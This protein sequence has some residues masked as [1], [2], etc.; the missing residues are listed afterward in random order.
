[1]NLSPRRVVGTGVMLC[2][3]VLGACQ[4]QTEA[5][6]VVKTEA[7]KPATIEVVK[8]AERS[9]SFLA[10]SRQLELGGTLYGYVD[11][12]GDVAKIAGSLKDVLGQVS[13]T[14]PGVAPFAQQDFAAIA[15]TL[16]LTDV[17]AVG[18]SSVPDG[19]GFFR[20]RLFFYTGGERRGLLAGFG[21]KP[22]PFTHVNLAPADAAFYAESEMDLAQV[23]R[24]IHE[25][26]AKVGGEAA[27]NQMETVLK[28]AGDAAALS[29]LD[30]IY[31]LKGRNAVVLRLDA[32]KTMRIPGPAGI[33]LP[34]I[35]I[36][37]CIEGV[38]PVV[39]NALAKSPAFRR[40]DEGAVHVYTPAQA[41]PLPGIEPAIV[42]DGSTLFITTSRTFL[43]ECR[44]QKTGLAQTP[45]FQQALAHVGTEGNGLTY[46]S[47]RF[48][49]QMQRIETLNPNMPAETRATL[50]F[51][52]SRLSTPAQ[53]LVAVRTN[54]PDGILVRSY[55]NRSLKQDVAMVSLYNPVSVGLVAAMAIPAFQ[56]VRT[57]SQEKA[58]MNNL[59]Q[60]AAAA[61]QYYLEHGVTSVTYDQIVGPNRYVRV[62]QPVAGENYRSL[63]FVQGRPLRVQL[64]DGRTVE[65]AP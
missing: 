27:G 4:K 17:K 56:K 33:T 61:D 62:I 58:V 46:V 45:E 26:V 20:N 31:G 57:A 52:L 48:F 44:T 64:A 12:E 36:A 38:A 30:L 28:K 22:G 50:G 2:A 35:S 1:M 13:R 14:Q 25:V 32:N 16:G 5:P 15:T 3:L 53:P 6:A 55:L 21:G 37:I 9:R 40:A 65:Y 51:V 42:A 18:V 54:L 23:Y 7:P 60:L 39:E 43:N 59:R 41:V 8:D 63:I 10:V 29:L 47:P 34:A 49:E 24:T 11:V 19:S